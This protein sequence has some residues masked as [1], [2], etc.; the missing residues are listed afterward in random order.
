M[1]RFARTLF[2]LLLRWQRRRQ[3]RVWDWRRREFTA[4][5]W[6]TAIYHARK[7]D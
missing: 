5:R 2:D 6:P 3:Q 1:T 7:D 4:P